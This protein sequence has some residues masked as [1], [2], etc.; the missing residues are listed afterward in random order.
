MVDLTLGHWTRALFVKQ[1]DLYLP[2]FEE[3]K[4]RGVR[5]A[6]GVA[7]LFR[8]EGVGPGSRLLDLGCGIGRHAVPLARL[9]YEIVGL[10]LSLRYLD[11][12]RRYARAQGVARRT[13]FVRGDFR[14]LASTLKSLGPFDGIHSGW[15]SIGYYG[16]L[17][18]RKALAAVRRS[19]RPGGLLV[20]WLTNKDWVL[21][22][23]QARSWSRTGGTV[24]LEDRS[25]DR[26]SSFLRSR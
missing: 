20:L 15:T 1:P 11:L 25:F 24:L 12:A 26:R 9:G 16:R 3:L 6:R 5:E 18:D 4:E 19:T 17:V 23:F 22:H 13:Q 10:D 8:R 21:Q 14:N 7:R 2:F